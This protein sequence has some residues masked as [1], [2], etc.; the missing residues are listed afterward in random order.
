[1]ILTHY[2]PRRVC[3]YRHWRHH[4]HHHYRYHRHHHIYW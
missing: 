3:H 1:V 4:W 2:G